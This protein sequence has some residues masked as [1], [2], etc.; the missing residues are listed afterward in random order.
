MFLNY[1][2]EKASEF[3]KAL[4]EHYQDDNPKEDTLSLREKIIKFREMHN[5]SLEELASIT[6]VERDILSKIESRDAYPSIS[7]INRIMKALQSG[8]REH[9]EKVIDSKYTILRKDAAKEEPH[10]RKGVP[11]EDHL[12]HLAGNIDKQHMKS[13]VI[14]LGK[15]SKHSEPSCHDGEEFILVLKGK[16]KIFLH[17][18]EEV[19]EEGDS[20]YYVSLIPHRV[21]N[22]DEDESVILA[23]V[24]NEQSQ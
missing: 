17:T 1:K 9:I 12:K 24:Y 16:V 3:L 20:I 15:S 8:S 18:K 13:L 14:T 6:G 22:I 21:E 19:L 11:P 5:M 10:K 7:S 23:V 2:S 4:S